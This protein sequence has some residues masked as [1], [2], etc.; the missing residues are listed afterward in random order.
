MD[1]KSNLHKFSKNRV[2][3]CHVTSYHCFW[4]KNADVSKNEATEVSNAFPCKEGCQGFQ[5]GGQWL[6]Y[7]KWFKSYAWS[8]GQI[9]GKIA[10]SPIS[11]H[12]T[13]KKRF[14]ITSAKIIQLT[15]IFTEVRYYEKK[16]FRNILSKLG[17]VTFFPIFFSQNVLKKWWRQQN[18]C[19]TGT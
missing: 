10:F 4:P 17:Q 18:W 13:G 8:N 11:L 1:L 16:D 19:Q 5:R 3:W 15:S 12:K 6:F 7:D 14:V 2:M 9:L